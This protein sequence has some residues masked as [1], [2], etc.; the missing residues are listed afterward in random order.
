MNKRFVHSILPGV[1][2]ASG[3][4]ALAG[5]AWAQ[6]GIEVPSRITDVR[7][8]D[9]V[10]NRERP[11]F[12]P[13]GVRVGSFVV[14]PRLRLDGELN[15]NIFATDTGEQGDF[16]TTLSPNLVVQSD[17]GNHMLRFQ[18][19]AD[20]GRYID[21]DSENFEDY[22]FN[23]NGRLD[24]TR[25]TKLRAGAGYRQ[26]HEERSSPD[27]VRGV[28]PT[29][30][31]VLSATLEGSHTFNRV[32]LT[33]GGAFD[34]YDFEDVATA[35]GGVINNDDRDR[36]IVEGSVQVS[37]EITPLYQAFVRGAYNVRDYDAAVD[38]NGVNRDSDGYEVVAG[39]SLDFGGIT[40][41][42]FFAGY[43][44]QEYDDP[45]LDTA[46]GPVVGADVTW[47][48]TP[49][50]TVVGSI[51]RVIRESTSRDANTGEF[52]SGRFFTTVGVSVDHELM[53]NVLLGADISA[54]QD[55]FEGIDRT[56]EIY[57][58]GIDAKYL[59][60][61]YA[62]IGGAYRFRMRNSDIGSAEFIENVFL[63]R[64][65]VQY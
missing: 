39:V 63:V 45:L 31:D 57:R 50:T 35:G 18:S 65:Q 49:L 5:E 38:D 12:D 28:E 42:D 9:T 24:V 2:L 55:D 7:R 3:M 14:L 21:N 30:F 59:I 33:L 23:G 58:A 61:R 13:L 36:D 15:D 41:G 11:D 48:V 1:F 22:E 62:S 53:R 56:D 25:R 8:G 17:W 4:A 64:L 54:S 6:S 34:Q 44:S 29:I 46:S 51:S 52:A 47:N 26:E 32:T 60:N 43:Q 40:F 20:I 37:Y 10:I 19:G 16:I 27:D